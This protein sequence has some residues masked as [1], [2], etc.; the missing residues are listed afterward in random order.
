MNILIQA[1]SI[2][3]TTATWNGTRSP[4]QRGWQ[5]EQEWI[6]PRP[7][8]PPLHALLLDVPLL[9]VFACTVGR[10][11]AQP[12]SVNGMVG[13]YFDIDVEGE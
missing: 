9:P 13:K 6:D 11:G 5:C 1:H 12:H 2:H 10:D 8:V 7:E 3:T 4:P